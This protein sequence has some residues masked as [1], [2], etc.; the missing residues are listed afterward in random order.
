MHS[1]EEIAMKIGLEKSR[2]SALPLLIIT[3]YLDYLTTRKM[4]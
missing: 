2:L 4:R 3:T 1:L